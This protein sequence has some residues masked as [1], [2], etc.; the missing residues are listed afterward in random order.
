MGWALSAL[1]F[2]MAA[3]HVMMIPALWSGQVMASQ[4]D[5]EPW[6]CLDV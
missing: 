6:I 1:Y 5:D 4:N 2:F 3:I